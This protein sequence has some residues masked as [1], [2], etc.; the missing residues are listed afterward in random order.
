M[1]HL[2]DD[3]QILWSGTPTRA[4]YLFGV[5]I[6][7]PLGLSLFAAIA[8]HAWAYQIFEPLIL[9]A[10]CLGLFTGVVPFMRYRDW[11]NTSYVLTDQRVFF[12][13]LVGYDV[14][15][16]TDIR[17]VQVKTRILDKLFNTQSVYVVYR[18]FQP[19]SSKAYT[20]STHQRA[21]VIIH[22]DYPA[23]FFIKDA[24]QVKEQLLDAVQRAKFQRKIEQ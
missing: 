10:I 20:F 14:V 7:V 11:K 16:L 23:F 24:Q 9:G 8:Y 2:N 13:T 17:D 6:S 21:R 3:E 4:P 18:D 12:D 15:N 19:W 5:Y 1:V 22:Q